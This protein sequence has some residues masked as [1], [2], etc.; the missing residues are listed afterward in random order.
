MIIC[1]EYKFCA[2]HRN[3]EF[4]DKCRNLHGHRYGLHCYFKV[5]RTSSIST[6]FQDFDTKIEPFLKTEYDHGMLINIHDPLYE[7]LCDHMHRTGEQFKLKEF[8][9]PTS[10]ENI[11][12]RL[13]TEISE[14][15]F[16]LEKIEVR[17]TDTS[18]II[19]TR[20]DWIADNHLMQ[21]PIKQP[22]IS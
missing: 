3:E 19:Y 5:V 22:Q 11:A 6:P 16:H 21:Y 9:A 12:H 18:V 15:G 20:E 1:K 17:E 10:V 2:A 7:T 13:F 14:M 8:D 4:N